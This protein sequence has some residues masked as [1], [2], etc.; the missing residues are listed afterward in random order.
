[1]D[2]LDPVKPLPHT[3]EIPV[4]EI[5][6]DAFITMVNPWM[7]PE[8]DQPVQRAVD[9]DDIVALEAQRQR[10]RAE[11]KAELAK[12][13]PSWRGITDYEGNVLPPPREDPDVFDRMPVVIPGKIRQA[14]Q[15]LELDMEWDP[16]KRPKKDA[17]QN[18]STNS[19]TKSESSSPTPTKSEPTPQAAET[20]AEGSNTLR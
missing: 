14:L 11:Q 17:D 4:P 9:R 20:P 18:Q 1:L 16:T 8:P 5:G 15:A 19:A 13:I 2:A 7:L 3:R 12:L 6:P 10:E